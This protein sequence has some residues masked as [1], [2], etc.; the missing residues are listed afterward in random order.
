MIKDKNQLFIVFITVATFTAS[1]IT[2]AT[3]SSSFS[4]LTSLQDLSTTILIKARQTLNLSN[5]FGPPSHLPAYERLASQPVFTV[6]TPWGSPYLL[7]ERTD[8]T[9]SDLEFDSEDHS[10][11]SPSTSKQDNTRQVALYFMDEE[12]AMRL[13][14]EMLQMDQMKGVD[15]RITASSLSKAVSQSVNLHKGLL[16]GQPI[17]EHSGKMKGSEEGGVLRYKIVPPKRELFYAARCKGR[18]RVGLWGPSPEEDARLMMQSI[19]VIGGSLALKR[20]SLVDRRRRDNKK[21]NLGGTSSET[22][23]GVGAGV[24]VGVEGDESSTDVIREKYRHMEGFVGIPVFHCPTMKKYNAIKGILKNDRRAQVPLYFS[25][26]DLVSSYQAMRKRAK[27]PS[28]IPEKPEVEVFNLMD[29]VTSMDRDQWKAKRG[30]EIKGWEKGMGGVVMEKMRGI[31]KG[32][33]LSDLQQV[34]FIPNS[35]NAKFKESI[36]KIGNSQARGLR[37]MRPWGRDL[38]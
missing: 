22:G 28:V 35:K 31:W 21:K 10:S 37:P 25:Y 16:T 34:I 19:P 4:P 26:E 2:A 23:A 30:N 36:S 11:S 18:E 33:E 1:Q 20:K 6:T 12:D 7:F 24:G 29:V 27:D 5:I 38:M 15:M 8:R 17:D 13:R 3:A 32:K 14:D 9:E